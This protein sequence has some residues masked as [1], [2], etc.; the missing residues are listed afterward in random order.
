[1]PLARELSLNPVYVEEDGRCMFNACLASVES[2][3]FADYEAL[4]SEA[5]AFVRRSAN[6]DLDLQPFASIFV[7]PIRLLDPDVLDVV[8]LVLS[9]VLRAKLRIVQKSSSGSPE[10]IDVMNST[11]MSDAPAVVLFRIQNSLVRPFVDHYL[12]SRRVDAPDSV[13]LPAEC[14]CLSPNPDTCPYAEYR[15]DDALVS[16]FR[17]EVLSSDHS[18]LGFAFAQ[19]YAAVLLR[20]TSTALDIGCGDFPPENST[21]CLRQR[22]GSF[23]LRR[24]GSDDVVS[25]GQNWRL[26]IFIEA[27][28]PFVPTDWLRGEL[29][30]NATEQSVSS[31]SQVSADSCAEVRRAVQSDAAMLAHAESFHSKLQA[32]ERNSGQDDDDDDDDE[33]ASDDEED[34]GASDDR[35]DED[36]GEEDEEDDGE[37][38]SQVWFPER[39]PSFLVFFFGTFNPG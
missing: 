12:G 27:G 8:P 28:F 36:V 21:S 23:Y 39:V 17:D 4:Y 38:Q 19:L 11:L 16:Y 1:M 5:V 7:E 26:G 15:E 29:T 20:S 31:W 25:L 9:K 22:N 34:E 14:V 13:S 18:K 35:E 3:P 32:F 6:D 30:R 37:E 2:S 10:V 24:L 33:G